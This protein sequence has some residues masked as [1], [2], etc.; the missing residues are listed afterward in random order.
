MPSTSHP[1]S[2]LRHSAAAVLA[3]VVLLLGTGC[4]VIAPERRADPPTRPR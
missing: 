2:K 4:S 1:A 3:A